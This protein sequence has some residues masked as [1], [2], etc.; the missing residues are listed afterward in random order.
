MELELELEQTIQTPIF[1]KEQ[2]LLE[3]TKQTNSRRTSTT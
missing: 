1:R 3:V 2:L